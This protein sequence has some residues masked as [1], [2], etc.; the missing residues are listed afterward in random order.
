MN[1]TLLICIIAIVLVAVLT[2]II[3]IRRSNKKRYKRLQENIDKM[4]K[5]KNQDID[6]RITLSRKNEM[7]D[8]HFE[9]LKKVE[10][11]IETLDAE[12]NLEEDKNDNIDE[13]L[14]VN[15]GI[16]TQQV[17][18]TA[19]AGHSMQKVKKTPRVDDFEK[20]MDEHAYSR[21]ILGKDLRNKMKGLSPQV[22]ALI[23]TS[24]LNK[25][26]DDKN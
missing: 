17:P 21:K 26:D 8:D 16:Q 12:A 23:L 4:K 10:P 2:I 22:K 13:I 14:N 15:Q 11:K 7:L 25:F 24:V 18:P 5:Q 20:F 9:L 6:D 1:R 3:L 19:P